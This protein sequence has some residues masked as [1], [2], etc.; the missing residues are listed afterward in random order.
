M[1]GTGTLGPHLTAQRGQPGPNQAAW[2]ME[3]WPC[4]NLAQ[5]E[6][7]GSMPCYQP[8]WAERRG[9]SVALIQPCRGRAVVWLQPSPQGLG[10]WQQESSGST[11]TALL[12]PNFA[13]CGE[14]H[15]LD[16]KAP[17]A[18]LMGQRLSTSAL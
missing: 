7:G 2:R 13:T 11:T 6:W 4:P 12:P 17:W 3:A 8:G 14:P 18:N 10:F 15:W 5:W 16:T 1:P 9:H